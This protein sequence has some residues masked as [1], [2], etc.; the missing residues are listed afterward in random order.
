MISLSGGYSCIIIPYLLHSSFT[1]SFLHSI[2]PSL[3]HS[4]TP[5]FL[6]SIIPSLHRSFTPS[7]LHSIFPSLHPSFTP[8]FLH[9]ILPS[10]HP[11]FTPPFIHFILHS[12]NP[13]FIPPPLTSSLIHFIF[14]SYHIHCILP[15]LHHSF[16]PSL[17]QHIHTV[18]GGRMSASHFDILMTEKIIS[19]SLPR[20]AFSYLIIATYPLAGLQ[21]KYRQLSII[22]QLWEPISAPDSPPHSIIRQ[23]LMV[24]DGGE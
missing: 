8:S 20:D 9:S 4:F 13:P 17:I 14:I 10:L 21:G 5:S 2:L 19:D 11:S 16:T 3:H 22:R 6:H 15:S 23:H 12:F 1:P 18:P 24:G 7:F